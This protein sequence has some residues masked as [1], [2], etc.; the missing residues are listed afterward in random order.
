MSNL[1]KQ[2]KIVKDF[3]F[4]GKFDEEYDIKILKFDDGVVEITY[5]TEYGYVKH[6]TV[7][8]KEIDARLEADIYYGNLSIQLWYRT[9]DTK[10]IKVNAEY[11]FENPEVPYFEY[12]DEYERFSSA[13]GVLY[14]FLDV[15][16]DYLNFNEI[17][18]N[19]KK[20]D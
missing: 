19:D 18:A 10:I 17:F 8:C 15:M 12:V 13:Y 7:L 9:G 20:E 2:E 3:E 5:E 1:E 4:D 16:R 11:E 14:H 6:V